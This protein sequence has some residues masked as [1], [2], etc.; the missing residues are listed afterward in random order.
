MVVHG[1][2]EEMERETSDDEM[3]QDMQEEDVETN[4]ERKKVYIPGVS[5]PL[6]EGEE[7][8]YDPEAYRMFHT[9]E[10][11]NP[12]LS[13][14]VLNDNLGNNRETTPLTCYLVG[15]TQVEKKNQ[16]QLIVMRLSNMHSIADEQEPSSDEDEGD[17]EE[18]AEK[19]QKEKEPIL[20]GALIRHNGEINR[21]KSQT[22]GPSEVCAVWNSLGKVQIWNLSSAL[23]KLNELDEKTRNIKL[24]NEKPLYSFDGHNAEGFA[25]GWSPLKAGTLAS[26][27]QHK[28]IFVWQMSEGGK[29][30]VNQ[31]P[32]SGHNGSV[33]DI[34]WSS[35]EEPL[36]ISASTDKS[37]RLW[38]TRAPQ[39]QACV[40]TVENAHESDVNVVSWNKQEPL[41]VSGSDDAVIKV[42]SLKNIQY[43]QSVARF[44]HH[45]SPITSIEW[46]PHDST[47]FMASGEDNQITFWDLSM[48]TESGVS[49][50]LEGVPPQLLFVHMG[51]EEIKEVHWHPKITGLALATALNGF[52]AFRTVNI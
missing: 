12:C 45:K 34:Q 40:C 19:K 51:L 28:K 39:P 23:E 36:L 37:I 22:I 2:D 41:I 13:F 29:W 47:T 42:W 15:G 16:N 50:D 31:R 52:H 48:E 38:D 25:L 21:V 8:D 6:R 14:D 1:E 11:D 4:E 33:E 32:L 5:R 46:A 26:G 3:D 44:K 49:E 27:D 35:T 43:G 17:D 9:F 10:T 24:D 18:E 20:H 7:L 30:H